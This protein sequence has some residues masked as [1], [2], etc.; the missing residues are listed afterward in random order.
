MTIAAEIFGNGKTVWVN[1][2]DGSSLGRFSWAGIDIHHP[3][4]MQMEGKV[5]Y[6]CRKGPT[7]LQ[8]WSDF[9]SIMKA[10]YQA[11]ISDRLMPKFLKE[12][13]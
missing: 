9:K 11:E 10:R 1:G 13:V 2:S 3:V 6:D 12:L 7:N 5:C 4:S 8:D